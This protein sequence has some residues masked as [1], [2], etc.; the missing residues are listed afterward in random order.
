LSTG[1]GT[2]KLPTG[3]VAIAALKRGALERMLLSSAALTPF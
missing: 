2:L 3:I 1:I